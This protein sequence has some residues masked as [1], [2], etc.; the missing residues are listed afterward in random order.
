MDHTDLKAELVAAVDHL[1]PRLK[2]ILWRFRVPPAEAE[3]IL[4]EVFIATLCAKER[5]GDGWKIADLEGWLM[6]VTKYR[7]I[8]Y[9]RHCR[10]EQRGISPDNA[11]GEG[12]VGE[13]DLDRRVRMMD[14]LRHMAELP[15][16]QRQVVTLRLYG[17]TYGEIA[18]V[19]GLAKESVRKTWERTVAKLAAKAGRRAAP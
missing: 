11:G 18:P 19:V 4:Q 3:D 5:Y 7:C 10:N 14:T 8:V 13:W 16:T 2:Q 17:L 6:Q 12:M 1:R 15:K 9:R